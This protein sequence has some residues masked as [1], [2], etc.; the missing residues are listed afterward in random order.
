MADK[1]TRKLIAEP[2]FDDL[3]NQFNKLRDDLKLRAVLANHVHED[4]NLAANATPVASD[5]PTSIALAN[6]LKA[7]YN[8]HRVRTDAHVAADATNTLATADATDLTTCGALL[9]AMKTAFNAHVAQAG[10]HINNDTNT[11]TAANFVSTQA[12]AN[13]LAN[14]IQTKLNAHM[15]RAF[16][17]VKIVRGKA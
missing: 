13:T 1:T 11:V 3:V 14:D 5:L 2:E 9:N 16:T 10:V 8:L 7:L 15:A 17:S 12:E 6:A 4:N